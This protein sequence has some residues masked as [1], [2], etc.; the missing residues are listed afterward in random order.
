MLSINLHLAV[1]KLEVSVWKKNKASAKLSKKLNLYKKY[2]S[3]I[4]EMN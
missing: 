1:K 3:K 2:T 4:G